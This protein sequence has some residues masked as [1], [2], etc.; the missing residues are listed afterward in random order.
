MHSIDLVKTIAFG[1][2]L[3]SIQMQSIRMAD[4]ISS[5]SSVP[6]TSFS[7]S[8]S[9]FIPSLQVSPLA[10]LSS[11][12]LPATS[13]S[14][15]ATSSSSSLATTEKVVAPSSSQTSSTR[16]SWKEISQ[17]SSNGPSTSSASSSSPSSFG[18]NKFFTL[19]SVQRRRHTFRF[20]APPKDSNSSPNPN[21][22]VST[23]PGM[24]ESVRFDKITI[25]I[26]VSN[27]KPIQFIDMTPQQ[28]QSSAATDAV[29][30]NST[31]I[32]SNEKRQTTSKPD[33]VNSIDNEGFHSEHGFIHKPRMIEL[34]SSY[35]PLTLRFSTRPRKINIISNDNDLIGQDSNRHDQ[36]N[37][38]RL[39][40]PIDLFDRSNSISNLDTRTIFGPLHREEP[41]ILKRGSSN[42]I[43]SNMQ[44][45]IKCIFPD[46]Q[47]DGSDKVRSAC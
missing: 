42:N 14:S 19:S 37:G 16:S 34:E 45:L 44:G 20:Q 46:F 39:S 26:G 22:P 9:V 40:Q 30:L 7:L 36:I 2:I 24:P 27:Y 13:P 5:F 23:I 28:L 3:F 18:Q 41:I 10:T 32:R 38:R 35:I 8:P 12:P 43:P 25:P 33:S 31:S 6:L 1:S 29:S 4:S 17:Q 11:S 21:D 15:A 47:F